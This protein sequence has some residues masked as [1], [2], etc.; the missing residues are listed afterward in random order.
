MIKC[1]CLTWL[2]VYES[3]VFTTET[4]EPSSPH[5]YHHK[6]WVLPWQEALGVCGIQSATRV[7]DGSMRMRLM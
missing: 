6:C 2:C 3:E 5:R 1:S 7:G 4:L